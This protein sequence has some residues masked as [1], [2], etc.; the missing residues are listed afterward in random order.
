MKSEANAAAPRAPQAQ[1]TPPAPAGGAA[2]RDKEAAQARRGEFDLSRLQWADAGSPSQADGLWF[3]QLIQPLHG[4]GGGGEQSGFGGSAAAMLP[5][6]REAIL[7]E[8]LDELTPRLPS[9]PGGPFNLTLIMPNL[10]R[11][12]VR[13][14][15]RDQ[16]WEV[17]LGFEREDVLQRLRQQQEQCESALSEALRQPVR[18]SMNEEVAR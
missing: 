13:A 6:Q 11:V 18:L 16:H 8:L 2:V 7:G 12:Q 14:G 3:A 4:A 15:K 17:D 10:G 9:Q 5:G 1:S